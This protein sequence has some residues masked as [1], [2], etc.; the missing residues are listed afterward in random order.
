MKIIFSPTKK[1]SLNILYPG[2]QPRYHNL[3][4]G[5]YKKLQSYNLEQLMKRQK[6]SESIARQLQH[7]Y[8]GSPEYGNAIASYAGTSFSQLS[9][10]SWSDEEY[11]YAE[12]HIRIISAL[13]GVLQPSNFIQ[14]HRLDLNDSLLD[15]NLYDF[16]RPYIQKLFHDESHIINLASREY[17]KI[18]DN[19]FQGDI[20]T[21]D[22]YL[23]KEGKRKV[24]AIHAKKQRGKM[25][26]ALVKNK[27]TDF[28]FFKRY[29]SDGFNY[30]SK[31]S[32]GTHIVYVKNDN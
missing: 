24:V 31:A 5:I 4:Q 29:S 32:T 22:F 18:F 1:Q 12:K 2:T 23:E 21:C 14:I 20:I 17:S 11:H 30:D 15:I 8:Q 3:S 16:W 19:W 7:S 13:Y 10:D 6:I 9:L 27:V 26:E 25:L 28:D